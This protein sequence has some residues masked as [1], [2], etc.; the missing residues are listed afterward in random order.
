[1]NMIQSAKN[2]I[3]E[4]TR[5]AYLAAAAE[6]LLS[7][8]LRQGDAVLASAEAGEIVLRKMPDGEDG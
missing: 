5:K 3:A 4:L 7:G 6:G 1:M 2:Q 8:A